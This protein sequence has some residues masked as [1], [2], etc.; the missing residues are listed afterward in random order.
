MRNTIWLTSAIKRQKF[1]DDFASL[2]NQYVKTYKG[3]QPILSWYSDKVYPEIH[4]DFLKYLPQNIRDKINALL[5][6][7]NN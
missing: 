4:Q 1:E 3:G 2:V 5:Q 6:E 7:I